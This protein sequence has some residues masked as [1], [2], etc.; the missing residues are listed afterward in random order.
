[1]FP[2]LTKGVAFLNLVIVSVACVLA[3][4]TALVQNYITN[5]L[6]VSDDWACFS[7]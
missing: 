6:P 5:Q 7:Q 4:Q 2:R 3:S 1:M